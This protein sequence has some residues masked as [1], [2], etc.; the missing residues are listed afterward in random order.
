MIFLNLNIKFRYSFSTVLEGQQTF[1][2]ISSWSVLMSI[3]LDYFLFRSNDCGPS[4]FWDYFIF[5]SIV[6][7]N[8][9]TVKFYSTVK[10]ITS[11]QI[12]YKHYHVW[13]AESNLIFEIVTL[14]YVSKQTRSQTAQ[15]NL[16][17]PF[18]SSLCTVN[19]NQNTFFKDKIN[20]PLPVFFEVTCG[21]FSHWALCRWSGH[22]SAKT[23][24]GENTSTLF[25]K[26]CCKIVKMWTDILAASS[27]YVS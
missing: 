13:P 2:W 6:K 23:N 19:H 17:F 10:S 26:D 5:L 24:L 18:A 15:L 9:N 7:F 21:S 3:C 27:F 8:F 11:L 1:I 20:R 14:N 4:L 25:Y 22:E 16:R 12:L